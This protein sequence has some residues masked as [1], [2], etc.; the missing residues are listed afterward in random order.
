[1]TD[2]RHAI[3]RARHARFEDKL[4]PWKAPVASPVAPPVSL[5][6]VRVPEPRPPREWPVIA[7]PPRGYPSIEAI[8]LAVIRGTKFNRKALLSP[9]RTFPLTFYRQVGMYLARELTPLSLMK[10]GKQFGRRDH[11]VTVNA[12]FK[13]K[14]MMAADP[15]FA[16]RIAA[17]RAE[18]EGNAE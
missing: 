16:A 7:L 14:A 11:S 3:M 12:I 17:L 2:L 1:M 4:V 15:A 9:L 6:V 18:I 10:I 8:Q 13:I 5:P